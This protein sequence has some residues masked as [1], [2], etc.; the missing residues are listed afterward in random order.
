[1]RNSNFEFRIWFL[2]VARP[3]RSTRCWIWRFRL[4][5]GWTRRTASALFIATSNRRNIFIT[6]RGQAK[7][8]DFGLAK[9]SPHRGPGA[10]GQDAR[11]TQDTPT[12]SS[13]PDTLTTPGMAIGTVAYMSPEQA[14]GEKLDV[15]TDLFSFGAVLYEVATGRIAFGGTS[16][17]VIL[18]SILKEDPTPACRLNPQLP[19]QLEGIVTKALEKNRDLRYQNAAEIRTDLKAPQ[20]R[21]GSGALAEPHRSRNAT[22]FRSPIQAI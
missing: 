1:M 13:D 10:H 5:M 8:L 2:K 17:A 21:L 12:A 16:T 14:R 3:Y 4:R 20:A 19:S 7:I 15:R 22:T 18:T 6:T 11:G 9:L